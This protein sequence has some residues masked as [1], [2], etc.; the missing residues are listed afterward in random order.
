MRK[1]KFI[2]S[3]IELHPQKRYF[4]MVS[5]IFGWHY[6]SGNHTDSQAVG[7]VSVL[8]KLAADVVRVRHVL[9]WRITILFSHSI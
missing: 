9:S 6:Q 2:S 3:T 7:S 5:V 4:T 8:S 1:I